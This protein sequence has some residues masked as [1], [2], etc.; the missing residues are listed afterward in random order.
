MLQ[1]EAYGSGT[2][3]GTEYLDTV[4]ISSGLVITNQS[5]GVASNS[6]GFSGFDGI[7]GSSIP[8]VTD[9]L[10]SQGAIQSDLVSV[11]FEPTT[12]SSDR[13]GEL[14]FGGTDSTKFT[15]PITYIPLT[16]TSPASDYWSISQSIKY[17]STT[18][19]ST[20]AGIVDSGTT[21]IPIANRCRA[22]ANVTRTDA[23]NRY[24]YVTGAVLDGTTGLLKITSTQYSNLQSLVFTA[25]GTSFELTANAQIWPRS[26]NSIIG[27]TSS[28]IYLV[29]T[30]LGSPSGSGL[31]FING[32]TFLERF[33]SVFDTAN[34]SVGFATTPFTTATTN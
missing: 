8:T 11:S 32:Y 5:I 10:Y 25:G 29:V 3:S 30:D 26:L 21:L 27:G 34:G 18:I 28:D 23:F 22:P 33:Y 15:G 6:S 9:N 31:D 13:N 19:L 14:T 2:F 7:L 20:T 12:S 16:T 4:T 17:G 1:S 24:Q